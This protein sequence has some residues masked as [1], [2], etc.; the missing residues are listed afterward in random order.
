MKDFMNVD[1][2]I[3][4]VYMTPRCRTMENQNMIAECIKLLL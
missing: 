3:A 4:N 1:T 2:I